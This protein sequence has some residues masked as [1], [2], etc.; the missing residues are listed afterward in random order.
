[1]EETFDKQD[2]EKLKIMVLTNQFC[3]RLTKM[4]ETMMVL[5]DEKNTT[6]WLKTLQGFSDEL[7]DYE[8]VMQS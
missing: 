7:E 2:I 4:S 8:S 6:A 5:T 1:M 3:Q